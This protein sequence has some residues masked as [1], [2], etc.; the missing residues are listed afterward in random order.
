[1]PSGCRQAAIASAISAGGSLSEP[2]ARARSAAASMPSRIAGK[3]ARTAAARATSRDSAGEIGRRLQARA[4][5]G[6]RSRVGDKSLRPHRAV[7]RSAPDRS[8]APTSRCASR[9]EP[10]AV[11]VRSIAS[12]SEPRRSPDECAHQFEIG[13][14]GLVDRE[15]R[16]GAFAQRRR[17]R[18]AL[19]DLRA[20][21]IG[22][23]GRGGGELQPAT[24][25]RRLRWSR[26]QRMMS[27]RRSAVA[28]S[29]T[30]R[31]KRRHRRQ[32]APDRAPDRHRCR[33]HRRR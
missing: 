21:D 7:A 17:Q 23:A 12:S 30:S 29:N 14:R 3:I 13:A 9:R 20:L 8:A 24:A 16:A 15:R 6:A 33:A 32:R 27:S 5:I 18:R 2:S 4:R 19:A 10:A 22:D 26:P 28:P 31:G 1:M 11:T 25:R